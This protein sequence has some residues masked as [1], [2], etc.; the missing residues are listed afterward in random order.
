MFHESTDKETLVVT[1]TNNI[2]D[3][4]KTW[5]QFVQFFKNT[6][7]CPTIL[8]DR[9][10]SGPPSSYSKFGLMPLDTAFDLF[11]A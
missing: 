10:E 9:N 5:T 3:M 11:N 6:F 4:C 1:D 7:N 2:V 8:F